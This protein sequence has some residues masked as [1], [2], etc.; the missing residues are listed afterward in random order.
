[1]TS[2]ATT[3]LIEKKV[4]QLRSGRDKVST[5]QLFSI[6]PGALAGTVRQEEAIKGI[7]CRKK[8]EPLF[9][10]D[11]MSTLST[12]WQIGG[13]KFN[14]LKPVAFLYTK[15]NILRK[16]PFTIAKQQHS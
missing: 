2:I 7:R 8:E 1:M 16:K 14:I 5:L 3:V 4:F 12:K 10:N 9:S 11:R 13:F 15:T 6:V